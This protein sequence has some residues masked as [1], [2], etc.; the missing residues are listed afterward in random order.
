M[1]T[2]ASATS[3]P[4]AQRPPSVWRRMR[5]TI[6][7]LLLVVTLIALLLAWIGR[8]IRA[9]HH[10]QV[11]ATALESDDGIDTY[12]RWGSF[13]DSRLEPNWLAIFCGDWSS[14]ELTDVDIDYRQTASDDLLEQIGVFRKLEDVSIS[15]QQVTDRGLA[16]LGHMQ[17]LR[18]LTIEACDITDK[19]LEAIADLPNLQDVTLRGVAVTDQGLAHLWKLPNL[20]SL[21]L[22]FTLVTP[23]AVK[24]FQNGRP[25]CVV[26]YTPAAGKP[27]VE[28]AKGIMRRD[29]NLL[30]DADTRLI[31]AMIFDMGHKPWRSSDWALLHAIP[32]LQAVSIDDLPSAA[33]GLREVQKLPNVEGL[34]LDSVP[35]TPGELLV[36]TEYPKL[37]TLHF[38]PENLTDQHLVALGKL[39]NLRVLKIEPEAATISRR[40]IEALA[41]LK[42][43]RHLKLSSVPILDE[44]LEPLAELPMLT[45]FDLSMTPVT[46]KA[47]DYLLGMPQLRELILDET[48]ITGAGAQRI[49]K[50]GH[51]LSA[52]WAE[53]GIKPE[54]FGRP[55]P[56]ATTGFEP[57]LIVPPYPR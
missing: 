42:Q 14:V 30:Y 51:I 23:K 32:E 15:G 28:A 2:T 48:Q 53:T 9:V 26:G 44:D 19:T 34:I 49:M 45:T 57:P 40:G 10:R 1:S 8:T 20:T 25:D 56:P 27:Q 3:S 6:R 33:E 31:T 29:A 35:V 52:T 55:P 5:W 7:T 17:E 24:A 21:T 11:L 36:L 18:S 50:S 12:L 38:Q 37:T 39:T 41:G 16:P 47:L 43:L 54:F 22:D 13:R 4:A 46:D